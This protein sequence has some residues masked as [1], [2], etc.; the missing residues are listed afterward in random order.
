[1]TLLRNT[2]GTEA[3]SADDE[4]KQKKKALRR[5]IRALRAV[6][7]DEEIHAMSLKVLEQVKALPEYQEAETLFVLS[8]IHIS[9]M[10]RTIGKLRSIRESRLS[11]SFGM[12]MRRMW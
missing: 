3:H 2:A 4:M 5:E 10:T 1:M 11:V 9:S 6:H 8:L 7:S 12:I